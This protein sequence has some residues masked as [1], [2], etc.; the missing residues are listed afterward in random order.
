[1]GWLLVHNVR[2]I[3][4]T[5]TLPRTVFVVPFLTRTPIPDSRRPDPCDTSQ[6]LWDAPNNLHPIQKGHHLRDVLFTR[7]ATFAAWFWA[8]CTNRGDAGA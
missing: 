4:A 7:D 3:G 2:Y 1:M 5:S 6:P 8:C